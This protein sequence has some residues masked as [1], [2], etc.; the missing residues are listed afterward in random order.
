MSIQE[1]Q[2][3]KEKYYSEAIRYMN[4]AKECLKNAKKEGRYYNDTFSP[5]SGGAGGYFIIAS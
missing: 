5:P 2:E 4:N 1:Q 3:L